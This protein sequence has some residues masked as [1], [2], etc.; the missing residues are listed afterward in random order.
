MGEGTPPASPLVIEID[1]ENTAKDLDKLNIEIPVLSPRIVR[2]YKNLTKLSVHEFIEKP[3]EYKTFSDEEQRVII[4]KDITTGEI[5]HET[6]LDSDLVVSSQSVIGYFT[7][8]IMKELRLVSGFDILYGKVK[9]FIRDELFGKSVDLDDL[10]TLRNLS[11][12]EATKTIIETFKKKINELTVVDKGEAEIRE[13]IK[14][15]KVRPF[16]VKNQDYFIPKKSSF[17]K[18]IGDSHFELEFASFLDDCNDIISYVKNYLA[19]H[20]QIDYQ[21]SDGEIS[22]YYPDFIVKKSETEYYVIETKGLEDLDVPLKTSRLSEWCKDVNSKVDGITF[23]W[24]F[25]EEDQFKKYKPSSFNQ[26][27]KAFQHD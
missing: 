27:I 19:V 24:I 1:K 20:F 15:N 7:Q 6:R 4:F 18:I 2:E 16:V 26:L 8:T 17:N 9:E 11:E 23:D 10:N 21:N 14:I 12:L 3:L 5:T 25:V 13:Y 22:N